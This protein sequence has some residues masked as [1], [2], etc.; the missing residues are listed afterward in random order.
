[1][2]GLQRVTAAVFVVLATIV[3]VA[4]ASPAAAS[5][6]E[7]LDAD[8]TALEVENGKGR[9]LR[10]PRRVSSVFLADPSIADVQVKSPTMIYLYGKGVGETTLFGLGSDDALVAS[11][12]I[13]VSHNV[14][15]LEAL[16]NQTV[17]DADVQVRSFE[18]SILVSGSVGTPGAA[19]NVMELASRYAAKDKLINRLEVT[20]PTQVNLRVRMAEV[21]RS[22]LE[23]FGV[24]W[25][26]LFNNGTAALGLATGNPVLSEAGQF[27]TRQNGVDNIVGAFSSGNVD[28]NVIFDFLNEEGLVTLLAQPN[29]T[30]STGQKAEFLAG[31]EFPIVVP[32]DN[33]FATVVFKEFGVSLEFT[34]TIL[35]NNR[36]SLHVLPEVSQLSTN[37]AVEVNGFVIPALT[38]RRAETRVELASGQSFAIAGLLQETVDNDVR[39]LPGLGNVPVLGKLFSSERYTRGESELVIVVT[40]YLVNPVDNP[41]DIK[42]PVAAAPDAL[43]ARPL[44]G[45]P[46]RRSAEP[47]SLAEAPRQVATPLIGGT[48]DQRQLSRR[49]A[50]PIGFILN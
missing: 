40:P 19:A 9:L 24:N 22:L 43:S 42:L 39:K 32:Q 45:G 34:P 11:M 28:F 36:I 25:Q 50:G 7:V 26:A 27:L 13:R 37:G 21:S 4:P 15:S 30:A 33:N 20:Q 1:M 2:T 47:T 46:S 29:L 10:F 48:E 14:R 3:A 35:D 6:V 5:R 38:T 17:K 41:A 18:G 49:L 16:I 23:R 12:T 31:G 44:D 8:T